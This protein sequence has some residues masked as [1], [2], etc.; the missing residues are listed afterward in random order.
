MSKIKF[1]ELDY[2]SAGAL[3]AAAI[4]PVVQD[5]RNFITSISSING[6]GSSYDDTAL[7]A[8]SG[9]WDSTYTTVGSYSASWAV[10]TAQSLQEV[11][12]I[13]NTTTNLINVSAITTGDGVVAGERTSTI[14][15][16]ALSAT[17]NDSVAVAGAYNIASAPYSIV[18]GG[19][20]NYIDPLGLNSALLGGINNRINEHERSVVLG[21][22]GLSTDA[23]DTVYVS[24]INIAETDGFKLGSSAT[25]GHV[26]T[27]DASGAGTWQAASGGGG[28]YDDSALQAASGNWD[29]TYTTVGSNSGSWSGG[30]GGTV[31]GTDAT[32]DIQAANEGGP[33]VGNARGENSVDLQTARFSAAAVASGL[34]SS[35][36]GGSG[37]TASGSYSTCS[38]GYMNTVSGDATVCGGGVVNSAAGNNG[39]IG[40]GYSNSISSYAGDGTIGG[41][42][43]NSISNAYSYCTIG[44]GSTNSAQYQGSTVA[45]GV[46]NAAGATGAFYSYCETVI[47]GFNNTA[48]GGYASIAGGYSSTASG[49]T[50]IAIG[51]AHTASGDFS[52]CIG[53]KSNLASGYS[54]A[55]I[56]GQNNDTNNLA[57]VI[58]AG[59][60]ITA[61]RANTLHCN[62]LTIKNIPTSPSG[63]TSGDVWSNGGVLTI[64]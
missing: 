20:S 57:D 31:Q 41:G 19:Y 64:V 51:E 5:G 15:G 28:D 25:P 6:N 26:L 7:Q 10:E 52:V 18:A 47:G 30:G 63:L 29:S 44:G 4:L 48:S 50:S 33:T 27:T 21:G 22:S 34:A 54:S 59:T 56:G 16:S 38:G 45:G 36:L 42:T 9:N 61:Q 62:N 53:G 13:G 14:G 8:A 39:V 37:N 3:N 40:G 58:I 11:T 23:D 1:S 43:N 12:D 32:Y 46:S 55:V 49:Y 17:G 60:G 24:N 35:V 2:L